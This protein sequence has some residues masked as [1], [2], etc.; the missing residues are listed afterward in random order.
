MECHR[1]SEKQRKT[2]ATVKNVMMSF[3]IHSCVMPIVLSS[4]LFLSLFLF[5]SPTLAHAVCV[6]VCARVCICQIIQCLLPWSCISSVIVSTNHITC[7]QKKVFFSSAVSIFFSIL[8]VSDTWIWSSYC[9]MY[10]ISFSSH[11][12]Y[13][14]Y[15]F[16]GK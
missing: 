11:Q 14:T 15:T 8:F 3:S 2:W 5:S 7:R 12:L 1:K 16:I 6:C 4:M 10:V 13:Y 9:C